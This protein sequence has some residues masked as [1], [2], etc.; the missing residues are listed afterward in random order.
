MAVTQYIGARYVPLFYT[1]SDNTNNWEA[2]VQY[3]PL[4]IVTYLNQS[5]ASKKPVPVSVGN[6]ADN[7]DYWVITGAYNAQVA[8]MQQDLDDLELRVVVVEDKVKDYPNY[9]MIGDS[10]G[11]AS[12]THNG[13]IDKLALK[14]GLTEG[15]D[16]FSSSVGGSGLDTTPTSFYTQLSSVISGMSADE[17]ADVGTV[18]IIGGSNDMGKAVSILE[19]AMATLINLAK[20]NCPNAEIWVGCGTGNYDNHFAT[21]QKSR[22]VEAYRKGASYGAKY[23]NNI[24]YCLHDRSVINADKVHPNNAGYD[25]LTNAIY[26]ALH[27]S[28]NYKYQEFGLVFTPINA[29]EICNYTIDIDNGLTKIQ[30]TSGWTITRSAAVNFGYNKEVDLGSFANL[31]MLGDDLSYFQ[32]NRTQINMVITVANSDSSIVR[33]T[34]IS[35]RIDDNGHLWIRNVDVETAGGTSMFAS[36]AKFII[37]QFTIIAPTVAC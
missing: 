26:A 4:T 34:N 31:N 25:E 8:Q 23:L 27:G 14:L 37:P 35:A 22:I 6:P 15:V 12:G 18:I 21:A 1:A 9:I 36:A 10:Y 7:P 30:T 17:L 5:Y 33:Q 13:W 3:E 29:T 16:L 20:T 28:F 19:P 11:Y 32:F 2:G 24:E